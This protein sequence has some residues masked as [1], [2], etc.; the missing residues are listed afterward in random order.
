MV[1]IKSLCAFGVAAIQLDPPAQNSQGDSAEAL[2]RK[3]QKF[4]PPISVLR[5]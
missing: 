3:R 4:E 2:G 1:G 5:G